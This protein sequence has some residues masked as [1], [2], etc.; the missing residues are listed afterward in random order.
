MAGNQHLKFIELTLLLSFYILSLICCLRGDTFELSENLAVVDWDSIR[1]KY[2]LPV[3]KPIF[4]YGGNLGKPQGIDYL[5]QC[6]VAN[7]Q[8]NDCHFLIVGNGTEYHK[9][10][11]WLT[12]TKVG[13]ISLFSVLPEND[14]DVLV[15]S[16][17]VGLI[18]LDFRFLM[19]NYPS[20][21]LSYLEFKMP[22]IAAT[23]I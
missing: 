1:K 18:F 13:N 8:R 3:G 4:I 5:I 19:Q 15:Q 7:K 12:N 21:L 17:D 11:N 2:N 20:R 9:L 14:Y 10:N 16:C 23:D 22:I 6:L